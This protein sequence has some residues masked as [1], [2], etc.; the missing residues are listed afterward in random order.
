VGVACTFEKIQ[1]IIIP[2]NLSSIFSSS[3]HHT[4]TA[5]KDA[6][7][8]TTRINH[9]HYSGNSGTVAMERCGGIIFLEMEGKPFLGK[10]SIDSIED[11][12][13]KHRISSH[14]IGS[15]GDRNRKP[16]KY[17]QM[18]HMAHVLHLKRRSS[19]RLPVFFIT[20]YRRRASK[21]K[22]DSL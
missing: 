18:L 20:G 12:Y 21:V 6:I 17:E 22:W 7:T 4:I 16:R 5:V 19:K 3:S 15:W 8:A 1:G 10:I 2:G 14:N 11:S 9:T 13:K